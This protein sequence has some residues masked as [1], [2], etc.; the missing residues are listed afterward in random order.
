MARRIKKRYPKES[1]K[2]RT[3]SE[4]IVYAFY[5]DMEEKQ[6]EFTK[7]Q[8]D[9]DLSTVKDLDAAH[10]KKIDQLAE[11]KKI[12]E[13]L[14]TESGEPSIPASPNGVNLGNYGMSF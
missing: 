10:Q 8:K 4:D 1:A 13:R 3:A 9:S 7:N 14:A 2:L 5:R 12:S 11:E 6:R